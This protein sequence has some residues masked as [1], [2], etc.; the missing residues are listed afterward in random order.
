MKKI[1]FSLLFVFSLTVAAQSQIVIT[2]IMY[3]P[4]ESGNDSLEYIEI[5]NNGNSGVTMSGWTLEFGNG[6]TI[7]NIPDSNRSILRTTK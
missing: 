1:I 5:L 7:F 6:P 3:N 4:P 2:E